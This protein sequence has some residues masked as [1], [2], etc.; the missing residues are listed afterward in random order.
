MVEENWRAMCADEKANYL[1]EAFKDAIDQQ[2][3]F[4]ADMASRITAL[5]EQVARL[6]KFIQE[7]P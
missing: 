7:N 1:R 2:Y 6:A 5:E 4:R 3:A